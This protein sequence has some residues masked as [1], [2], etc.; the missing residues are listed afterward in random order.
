MG[1][2]FLTADFE[3]EEAPVISDLT[4]GAVGRLVLDGDFDFEGK[5]RLG[6]FSGEGELGREGEEVKVALSVEE[7]AK[8][9]SLSFSSWDLI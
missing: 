9:A 2:D 3:G 7:I 1:G 5:E 8:N 4:F 6:F